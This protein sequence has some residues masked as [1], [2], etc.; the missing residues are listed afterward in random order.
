MYVCVLGMVS[1]YICI[2]SVTSTA[3]Y[4]PYSNILEYALKGDN[5]SFSTR[6]FYNIKH[7]PYTKEID[8]P[9]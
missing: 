4:I 9:K 1:L 5:P 2:D 8:V 7:S 3:R 6:F